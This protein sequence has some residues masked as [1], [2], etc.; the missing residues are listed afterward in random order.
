MTLDEKIGQMV[1]PERTSVTQDDIRD[2]GI[3]SVLSG[4]GSVP[5]QNTPQGWADMVD[6]FQK[7]AMTSR[8]GIPIIYGVDAVHGHNNVKMP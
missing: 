8:L 5:Q 1:Q 4:G 2:Y 6:N 7:G 3:G